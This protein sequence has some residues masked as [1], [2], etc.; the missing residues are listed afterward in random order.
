M[1]YLTFTPQFLPGLLGYFA[2]CIILALNYF[3]KKNKA[4]HGFTLLGFFSMLIFPVPTAI[5]NPIRTEV[6]LSNR[7]KYCAFARSSGNPILA[8]LMFTCRLEIVLA[9]AA[10]LFCMDL[11]Q[12]QEKKSDTLEMISFLVAV[13]LDSKANVYFELPNKLRERG[14]SQD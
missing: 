8:I 14:L 12:E 5:L 1:L 3:L 11:R 9:A 13:L 6:R 10:F 4:R 2:F 7:A